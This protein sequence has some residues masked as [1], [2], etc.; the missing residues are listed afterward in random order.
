[1][2]LDLKLCMFGHVVQN[3]DSYVNQFIS[4][5]SF[6]VSI[7]SLIFLTAGCIINKP[8]IQS[9]FCDPTVFTLFTFLTD[10]IRNATVRL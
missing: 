8:N 9:R 6:C 7:K 1:M 4:K 10:D 3:V 5:W 2:G